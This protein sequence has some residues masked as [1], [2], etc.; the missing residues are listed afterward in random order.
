[1]AMFVIL[2]IFLMQSMLYIHFVKCTCVIVYFGAF[3]K[4]VLLRLVVLLVVLLSSLVLLYRL[5]ANLMMMMMMVMMM[6]YSGRFTYINGY[7]SAASPIGMQWKFAG[8]PLSHPTNQVI[9]TR[10]L[11]LFTVCLTLRNRSLPVRKVHISM[12]SMAQVRTLWVQSDFAITFTS[13][14]VG[15]FQ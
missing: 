6:T 9:W 4:C 15:R 8:Q 12:V 7:P 2:P 11:K 10:I 1:M 3:C 13:V 14:V 5:W